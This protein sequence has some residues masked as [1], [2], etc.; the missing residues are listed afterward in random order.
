MY[1]SPGRVRYITDK[2][3]MF[4]LQII[5]N[6]RNCSQSVP[7]LDSRVK[8]I[9]VCKT[10]VLIVAEEQSVTYA[11]KLWRGE[12]ASKVTSAEIARFDATNIAT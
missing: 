11:T 5:G 3:C 8:S 6:N 9:G 12:S 1:S 10:F 4:K 7:S 2:M